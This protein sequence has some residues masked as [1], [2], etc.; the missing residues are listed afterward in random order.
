MLTFACPVKS[1]FVI[2]LGSSSSLRPGGAG[3]EIRQKEAFC[4]DLIVYI[5]QNTFIP[6]DRVNKAKKCYFYI[7]LTIASKSY[8]NL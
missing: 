4:K 7:N 8:I 6:I 1:I 2:N 5:Q 3:T